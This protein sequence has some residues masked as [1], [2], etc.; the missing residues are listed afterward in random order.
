MSVEYQSAI[1]ELAQ[2][3]ANRFA[4]LAQGWEASTPGKRMLW[5]C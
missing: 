4:Q 2:V 5:F 1:E 3:L